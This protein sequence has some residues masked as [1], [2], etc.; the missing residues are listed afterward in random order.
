VTRSA[1]A[2]LARLLRVAG[3][4][5]AAMGDRLYRPPP[6]EPTE[7][8]RAFQ[9]WQAANGDKTLRLQY[10]LDARSIVF[11]VGGFEGQ[12]ASDIFA[13]YLCRVH[14][15]EPVQD[16]ADAIVRRF[17]G[18]DRIKVHRVAL[19][20]RSG[21]AELTVAGDASSLY[22]GGGRRFP[23]QVAT[24][25]QILADENINEISLMK[26]NIEGAEYD[27]L[28]HM[29]ATG[30]IGRIGNLQVQFHQEI[31]DARTRMTAIRARLE[32]THRPTFQYAFVWENWQKR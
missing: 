28:E 17:A 8:E 27:L 32:A 22:R 9:A 26:L 20:P 12:W 29:I 18:N 11:D 16:F 14:V 1:A 7:Q 6:P 3:R 2:P 21:P 5:L 25:E 31:P 4:G 19:G 30:V 24:P 15:F 23:I 13:R 10:P